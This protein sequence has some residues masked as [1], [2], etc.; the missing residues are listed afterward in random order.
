MCIRDSGTAIRPGS[1]LRQEE[2]YG[3]RTAAAAA[4]VEAVHLILRG[5]TMSLDG[6]PRRK[7]NTTGTHQQK[8]ESSPNQSTLTQ[9]CR[10]SLK[11]SIGQ[12]RRLASDQGRKAKQ[13]Q[14]TRHITAQHRTGVGSGRARKRAHYTKYAGPRAHEQCSTDHPRQGRKLCAYVV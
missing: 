13:S 7:I 5:R 8:Q 3:R 9:R 11:A 4:T 1:L 14:H 12:S 6:P 2:A 10:R